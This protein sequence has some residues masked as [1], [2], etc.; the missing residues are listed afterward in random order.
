MCWI[1]TKNKQWA[2]CSCTVTFIIMCLSISESIIAICT[3]VSPVNTNPVYSSL[4]VWPV[5]VSSPMHK[6]AVSHILFDVATV[7]KT[8]LPSTK[9]PAR[10]E[11]S[12]KIQQNLRKILKLIDSLIAVLCSTG[13]TH[14]AQSPEPSHIILS[15]AQ[16]WWKHINP[17]RKQIK[18][19][20]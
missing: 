17:L 4:L 14:P 8:L 2:L 7:M 13:E 3:P 15:T 20:V 10:R 9:Q 18:L 1:S 11:D 6:R 12:A 19:L 16:Q 5:L